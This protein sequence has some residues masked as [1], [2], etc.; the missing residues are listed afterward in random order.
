ME[1]GRSRNPKDRKS[2]FSEDVLNSRFLAGLTPEQALDVLGRGSREEW[3][4]GSWLAHQGEPA[5]RFFLIDSGRIKLVQLGAGGA[6]VAV[7]FSVAG[8]VFGYGSLI[9]KS[10]YIGSALAVRNSRT[11]SCTGDAVWQLMKRYPRL[12]E[13]VVGTLFVQVI[14]L[15]DR[16]M[17]LASDSVERRLART[18]A[19]L[20]LTIG[21]KSASS[22]SISDGFSA[23]DLADL[24]GTTIFTVSRVLSEWERR[25]IVRKGRGWVVITDLQAL[26]QIGSKYKDA[27]PSSVGATS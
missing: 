16:C 20:A 23:R 15:Q 17:L 22:V 5:A 10:T 7:R 19:H 4:A 26:L 27:L 14:H 1:N 18:L 8:Q 9:K 6:N 13:N 12:A 24:S 25:G 2:S 11:L 3:K 21:R